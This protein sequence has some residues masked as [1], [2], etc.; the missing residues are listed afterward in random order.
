MDESVH[1]HDEMDPI[2]DSSGEIDSHQDTILEDQ[3]IA[4]SAVITPCDDSADIDEK[5]NMDL[6]LGTGIV[7]PNPEKISAPPVVV[8]IIKLIPGF[9]YPK[10]FADPMT[11]DMLRTKSFNY[12]LNNITR[13][14]YLDVI[15][16]AKSVNL[17]IIS[18]FKYDKIKIIIFSY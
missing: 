6:G 16:N 12:R 3:S 10:P 17:L 4:V 15:T 2:T 9:K 18:D 13:V 1:T 5:L 8:E 11:W 14:R 7:P